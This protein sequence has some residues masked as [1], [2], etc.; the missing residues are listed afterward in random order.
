MSEFTCCNCK[1]SYK[2]INSEDWNEFKAAE[3]LLTLYPECKNDATESICD[4]CNVLFREW[5]S[6]LTDKEKESMRKEA[7]LDDTD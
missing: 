2:K 1:V 3:E 4:D 5:F 7:A 6:K